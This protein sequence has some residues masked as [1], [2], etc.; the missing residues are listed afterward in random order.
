MADLRPIIEEII[1]VEGHHDK[2]VVER[3]VKGDVW[4]VGG[5]RIA[6]AFLTALRR[7]QVTRGVVILTD[8]DGPGER[9]RRRIEEAVPGCLHAFLARELAYAENHKKIGIEHANIQ[10][11]RDSLCAVRRSSM[12][13]T[14]E[15]SCGFVAYSIQDL[16]DV[17]LQGCRE[18]VE[19]RI[20]VGE[21]LQIGY[22]NAKSFVRK[23]N[24]LRI[25]RSE[26]DAALRATRSVETRGQ[27]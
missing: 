10:D 25:E 21:A 6:H 2:Q 17:G 18:A 27:S 15:I 20:Q 12:E 9:I 16:A 24:V 4:V 19:R 23:L 5:D 22:G 1:V 8:P 3:A 26:F 7:A 13:T 14:Q 11:I